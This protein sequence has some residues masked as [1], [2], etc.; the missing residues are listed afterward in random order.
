[1]RAKDDT[2]RVGVVDNRMGCQPDTNLAT[3][4]PTSPPPYPA[5]V[6]PTRH[7]PRH[8]AADLTTPLPSR[9]SPAVRAAPRHGAHRG[10]APRRDAPCGATPPEVR[11]PRPPPDAR[12]PPG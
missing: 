3:A 4:R 11:P 2:D 12:A 1:M 9:S 6:L 5:E 10:A 7:Q 8:R